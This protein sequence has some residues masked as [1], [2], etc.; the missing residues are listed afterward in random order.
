MGAE[1]EVLKVGVQR[2][3]KIVVEPDERTL[4]L[5]DVV[6]PAGAEQERR[7]IAMRVAAMGFERRVAVVLDAR[8]AAHLPSF[9]RDRR[10]RGGESLE[11]GGGRARD[12]PLRGAGRRL[13]VHACLLCPAGADAGD[14][15]QVAGAPRDR[16]RQPRRLVEQL[17]R[18]LVLLSL[19]RRLAEMIRGQP[20]GALCR[21][22]VGAERDSPLERGPRFL[23]AVELAERKADPVLGRRVV[24]VG[25]DRLREPIASFGESAVLVRQLALGDEALGLLRSTAGHRRREDEPAPQEHGPSR[26]CHL[27]PFGSRRAYTKKRQRTSERGARAVGFLSSLLVL[28]ARVR[29]LTPPAPSAP[30]GRAPDRTP[31]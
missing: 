24:R 11:V 23:P 14:A 20:E 1:V 28:T 10:R 3:V 30:A 21:R 29:A 7:L 18:S 13:E 31:D 9:R 8:R 27:E 2:L 5:H 19:E 4:A 26:D 12:L 25:G 6:V 22:E 17:D 16:R 15:G